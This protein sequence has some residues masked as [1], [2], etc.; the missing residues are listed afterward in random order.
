MQ[1]NKKNILF[2]S[3]TRCWLVY[4]EDTFTDSAL[5]KKLCT[6]ELT[7]KY[8]FIHTQK[9]RKKN[10]VDL[11]LREMMMIF[12]F[13]SNHH[14]FLHTG[15]ILAF[16]QGWPQVGFDSVGLR[17]R[18]VVTHVQIW[19]ILPGLIFNHVNGYLK[20]NLKQN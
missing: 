15:T 10:I 14:A 18:S 17:I 7:Q 2:D 11:V 12:S 5:E 13:S 4:N 20:N 19:T 6:K 3:L 1:I 16:K 8:N 9:E